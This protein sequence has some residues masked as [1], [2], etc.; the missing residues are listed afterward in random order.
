M[1]SPAPPPQNVSLPISQPVLS[2]LTRSAIF[3]VMTVPAGSEGP[4]RDLL[5]DLAGLQRT[6]GFRTPDGGLTVVA[7]IGSE[8]VGPDLLGSTAARLTSLQR[9]PGGQA[10]GPGNSGRSPLPHPG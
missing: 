4:V 3:L 7:G 8:H 9:G 2:P 1:T 10:P 6:V 5:S